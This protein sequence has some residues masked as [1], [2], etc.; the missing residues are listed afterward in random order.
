MMTITAIA[1]HC[2]ERAMIWYFGNQVGIDFNNA[3]PQELTN[4]SMVAE[5]GCSSICDTMGSLL[6]Y[7]NGKK[8]WNRN[9]QQMPNGDSLKGSQLLNQNSVIT[10]LPNSNTNYYLFTISDLDTI[11]GFNYSI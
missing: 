1:V 6:F 2:Q 8:V 10:P 11:R 5:A 7:T 3:N 4:S 9:H